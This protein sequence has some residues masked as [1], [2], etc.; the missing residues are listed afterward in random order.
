MITATLQEIARA[1]YAKKVLRERME[2]KAR[3]AR[4][5]EERSIGGEVDEAMEKPTKIKMLTAFD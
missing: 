5:Q 1:G 4:R 3:T 2:R